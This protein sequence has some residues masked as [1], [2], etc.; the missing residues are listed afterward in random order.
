MLLVETVCVSQLAAHLT[1][2]KMSRLALLVGANP[3]RC[4][5][6]PVVRLLPG[7]WTLRIEGVT[8]SV[9]SLDPF[10]RVVDCMEI[11][12]RQSVDAQVIFLI[13]GNENFINVFADKVA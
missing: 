9:I 4:S 1:E 13:R 10:G 3:K 2:D 5:T 11:L 12:A 6:G 8:D 7:L